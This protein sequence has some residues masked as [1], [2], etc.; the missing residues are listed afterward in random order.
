MSAEEFDG[1]EPLP[2][3]L[4][5]EGERGAF[6][7]P[8]VPLTPL[9]G[10]QSAAA[11][12]ADL[13]RNNDVRLV[14]LIG[15]GGVGKTRLALHVL[16]ER[17]LAA[18]FA[19]GTIFVSLASVSDPALVLPTIAQAIALRDSGDRSLLDRLRDVLGDR[20]LLLVLDNVE[21]V[22]GAGPEIAS[23]LADCPGVRVLATGRVPLRISGEHEF[24]VPPLAL[25]DLDHLPAVSDLATTEAV[26]LFVQR[27]QAVRPDFALTNANAAAVAGICARLDGLPLAIELAAARVKV[28][29]PSA[30]LA[31]LTNRLQVLTGGAR[32]L[33]DRLRTMRGAITWSHDLLSADEQTLF[34]HLAAF[35]GG[36]TL[37]AAEAVCG[38]ANDAETN[39][40]CPPLP[41]ILDG[42]ASLVDK[43]LLRQEDGPGGEPRFRM[44]ETIQEYGLERLAASGEEAAVRRRHA[45]WCL[46]LAEQADPALVGPDQD[47]W[48]DRLETEHGNLRA[49][50]GWVM[51]TGDA[52]TGL[53]LTGALWWF[54]QIRGYLG[55][56]RAWL[57]RAITLGRRTNGG[58]GISSLP[59]V[60]ALVGASML[61]GLQQ[62]D[63]EATALAEE[64]LAVA[65]QIGDQEG[66]A[67]AL[68]VRSFAAGG[69]GDQA[70]ASADAAAALD[71]FRD[72]GDAHWIAFALNRLGIE[73]Y[74][75]GDLTAAAG[76]YEEAL[77]RWR[78]I[79]NSWGIATALTNLGLVA[80]ADG[81]DQ[82]AAER[83]Q[84]ALVLCWRQRD[85]WGL[86]ELLVALA[87]IASLQ[88]RADQTELAARLL[89]A[90]DTVRMRAG[91]ILQPYMRANADRA[92]A[93]LRA[94]MGDGGYRTAWNAGRE[95]PLAEAIVA[96]SAVA[97]SPL[98]GRSHGAGGASRGVTP[99][100]E[101]VELTSRERDVLRLLVDG[102]SSREIAAELFISHR[103]VTTHVTNL[104]AKLGVDSRAAAVA[105]AFQHHLFEDKPHRS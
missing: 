15:P 88:G 78:R 80:R 4:E 23:L 65:R 3:A 19:D 84:E 11:T 10:R 103:T 28:L 75:Q 37:E 6:A 45:A 100:A 74:E 83:Y 13:L 41:D 62:D 29:S 27:A 104:L 93:A 82:L 91:L 60:R 70:A 7:A 17:D 26:E 54:W 32:D 14:T 67:R 43:S 95:M 89:G 73:T 30:L 34:R 40:S 64:A 98:A 55:E 46:A 50:L 31:R 102:R 92:E 18:A 47:F 52:E 44:L 68:F 71:L 101:A 61:A 42:L 1:Q 5:V 96:A 57:D 85:Q 63:E 51:E 2:F 53:R 25:P 24:L 22:V 97:S 21:Q 33:P 66:I 8:P 9:V 79:G 105:F 12:I 94:R 36:C 58:A 69:R 48:M 20:R 49:A 16:I 59:G 35:V 77:D 90:A 38:A 87:D 99:L 56:G 81:D 39:D 72:L 86:V 76:R